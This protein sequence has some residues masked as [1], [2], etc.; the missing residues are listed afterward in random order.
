MAGT[1][2][3]RLKKHKP[4]IAACVLPGLMLH[5]LVEEGKGARLLPVR[6]AMG[7]ARGQLVQ[8]GAAEGPQSWQHSG[9]PP[10]EGAG[11]P[12]MQRRCLRGTMDLIA[13]CADVVR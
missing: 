3:F 5:K 11:T 12:R 4:T 7:G 13:S 1:R 10:G 6:R 2:Q 8:A 9:A